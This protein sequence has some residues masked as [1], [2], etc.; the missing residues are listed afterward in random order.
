MQHR[1]VRFGR[2]IVLIGL[3]AALVLGICGSLRFPL[4]KL[5][6]N[7]SAPDLRALDR[8]A[9]PFFTEAAK[10]V[11]KV[12]QT[13]TKTSM[14]CRLCWAMAKDSI[15][16]G[17]RTRAMIEAIIRE[18]I[19]ENVRKGASIYKCGI[20]AERLTGVVADTHRY[21]AAGMALSVG[22]IALEAVLL[23]STLAALRSVLGATA[24][25]LAASYGGGAACAAA[26]GPFPVGDAVGVLMAA[27]GSAWCLWDICHAG[28][29]LRK[30]LTASLLSG[31]AECRETCRREVLK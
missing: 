29:R 20:R 25:R 9:Q 10:N 18:P 3:A 28:I 22:G 21:S 14:L 4:S 15:S 5:K 31:I 23:R 19:I 13:L 30:D 8:A 2:Y 1:P 7:S 17:N 12:V 16:K 24:A 27:G 6:L 26:D 11:P